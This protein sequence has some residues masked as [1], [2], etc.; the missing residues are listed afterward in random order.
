M[1][2]LREAQGEALAPERCWS[3]NVG[4]PG[5]QAEQRPP[6]GRAWAWVMVLG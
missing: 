1:W 6:G 3:V 2:N 5:V 4:S